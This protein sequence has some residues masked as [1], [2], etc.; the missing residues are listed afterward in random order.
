MSCLVR[1]TNPMITM[2][3]GMAKLSMITRRN[4]LYK[5]IF[6]KNE[7]VINNWMAATDKTLCAPTYVCK[8]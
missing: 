4:V 5:D 2:M 7:E 3:S 8:K 1:I 6:K